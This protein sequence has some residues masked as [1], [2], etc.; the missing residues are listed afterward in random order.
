WLR[1]RAGG[2]GDMGQVIGF[3]DQEK[4]P[5]WVLLEMPDGKRKGAHVLGKNQVRGRGGLGHIDT[6]TE[7]ELANWRRQ[8]PVIEGAQ[9]LNDDEVRRI[10]DEFNAK[11]VLRSGET[12]EVG[13]RVRYVGRRGARLE[14]QDGVLVNIG[15]DNNKRVAI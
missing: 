9:G 10:L 8:R 12:G 14:G 13:M 1:A 11:N 15:W 4:F 2:G 7:N 3:Y 5:G 6:P